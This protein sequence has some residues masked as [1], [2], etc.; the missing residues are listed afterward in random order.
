MVATACLLSFNVLK[1]QGERGLKYL[2][3]V[4]PV[5]FAAGIEAQQPVS[6]TIFISVYIPP[7]GEDLSVAVSKT[8]LCGD[9]DAT[10]N[11]PSLAT[12]EQ[13]SHVHYAMDD[14]RKQLNV[15][16]API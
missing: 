16:I 2:V 6:S 12:C 1:R 5:L 11:D 10:A 8:A 13:P 14:T 9:E 15:T 7:P 3:L 4:F